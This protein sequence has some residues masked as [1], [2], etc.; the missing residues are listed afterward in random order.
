MRLLE[1]RAV[2]SGRPL[3]ISPKQAARALHVNVQTIYRMI[4]RRELLAVRAGN[5][6]KI[7]TREFCDRYPIPEDYDFGD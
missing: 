4:E 5:R 6:I 1:R 2:S 3:F 7:P